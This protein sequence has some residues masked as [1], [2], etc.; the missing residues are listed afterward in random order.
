MCIRVTRLLCPTIWQAERDCDGAIERI[1]P[2]RCDLSLCRLLLSL[3]NDFELA[4]ALRLHDFGALLVVPDRNRN[5]NYFQEE[6]VAK[7]CVPWIHL[8][9]TH[10]VILHRLCHKEAECMAFVEFSVSSV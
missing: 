3:L 1:Q 7:Q 6:K 9:R 2:M 5:L 4:G 10:L 8:K